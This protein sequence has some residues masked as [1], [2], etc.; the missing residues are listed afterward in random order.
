MYADIG[1]LNP[2]SVRIAF[3]SVVYPSL[4]MTYIGQTAVV[5]GDNATYSSLYWSS[6]P[7]S[8]KWPSVVIATL[9]S[10]IAS[11]ALISGLF[12]VYH[13]AIHNNMFPR[14]AVV[15]TSKDHAG[16]IYIP[17]VNAAAFIGCVAVVL[18]FG[19]SA[20]MASAYGFS[21]SGVMMI[22]YILIS[23]VLVLMDKSRLFSIVY[24]VVFGIP[25]T[26]FFASTALKVPDGA[27][28]TIVIG[29][30]ISIIAIAWFRGYKAKTRY[31]KANKLPVRHMFHTTPTSSRNIIFYNELID[32][33]VPSYGQLTKLVSISGPSNV[34]LTVRKMPVSTVP[35][36][37][38]FLVSNHDGVDFVVARYGYSDVIDHGLPFT[39]KL[40]REINAESDDVTFVVGRTTL[41]TSKTSSFVTK[42]TV[43]A[44]NALVTLSSWTTDFFKTP[45]DELIA[46]EA[47]YTLS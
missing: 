40:C 7:T 47:V 3:C 32:S 6:I 42:I 26:L 23:I 16:Q 43:V 18:I 11:Q 20:N 24:G 14:L 1:H 31:I 19:E 38:R 22:T 46:F 41:A 10:I 5:L 2:A 21:V 25:T 4:L 34:V 39:R 17:V 44:Y 28:L 36:N 27:W 8:L 13:Q 29:F 37:E 35:E 15:Q 12:T 45:R 33:M 9:A 30:V